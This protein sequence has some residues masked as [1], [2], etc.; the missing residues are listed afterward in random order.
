MKTPL[1]TSFNIDFF[2]MFFKT[3]RP[4]LSDLSDDPVLH[5]IENFSEHVGVLKIKQARN[6]F[7]RF[8]FKIVTI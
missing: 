5:T 8:S 7:D 6:S 4:I 2:N 1:N 3:D